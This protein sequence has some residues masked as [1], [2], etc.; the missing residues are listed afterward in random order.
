MQ[1]PLLNKCTKFLGIFPHCGFINTGLKATMSG[2]Y[3]FTFF[4]NG[5]YY[6]HYKE[7]NEG[8]EIILDSTIFNEQAYINMYIYNP[9]KSIYTATYMDNTISDDEVFQFQVT[10]I[11]TLH[12]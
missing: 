2:I 8:T 11:N 1:S 5:F 4:M 10:I 7:F 3:S 9:D 12:I 6:Y